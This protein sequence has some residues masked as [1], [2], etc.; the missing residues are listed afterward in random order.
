MRS[1]MRGEPAAKCDRKRAGRRKER[2]D[3]TLRADLGHG[4]QA[5]AIISI[6][7][8]LHFSRDHHPAQDVKMFAHVAALRDTVLQQQFASIRWLRRRRRRG[9][10]SRFPSDRAGYMSTE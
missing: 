6:Q 8:L 2:L 5:N 4:R 3:H 1:Q 10:R 7:R 9:R